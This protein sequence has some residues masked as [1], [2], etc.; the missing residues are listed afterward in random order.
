GFVTEARRRIEARRLPAGDFRTWEGEDEGERRSRRELL[1]LGLASG[2][3]IFLLLCA[4]FGSSRLAL[5]VLLN[6]PLALV[7]GVLSALAVGGDLS[8]GS[9][10]GLITLFGISTRNSIMLVSHFR[11]LEEEEG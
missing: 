6:L 4:D 10:V 7:G 9:L 2:V 5:L 11:R 3:G 8:I 1:L